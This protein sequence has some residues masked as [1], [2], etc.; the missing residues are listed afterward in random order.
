MNSADACLLGSGN[1]FKKQHL[2][3]PITVETGAAVAQ[4][5]IRTH[6]A[7]AVTLYSPD[8]AH[9]TVSATTNQPPPP[10]HL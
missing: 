10:S 5:H 6:I 1:Q 7:T 2:L 9:R 4:N 3:A 8:S